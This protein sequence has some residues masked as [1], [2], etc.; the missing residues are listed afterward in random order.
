MKACVI[1]ASMFSCRSG[2]AGFDIA[3]ETPGMTR[4]KLYASGVHARHP[5]HS[6][7][8]S[9]GRKYGG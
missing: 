5:V 9:A 1:V 4:V 6:A 2:T 8:I 3:L 7:S